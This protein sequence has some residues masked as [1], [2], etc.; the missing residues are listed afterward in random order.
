MYLNLKSLE[1]INYQT[2]NQLLPITFTCSNTA[3][4]YS[5]SRN[6]DYEINY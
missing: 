2:R 3:K 4:Q 1:H 5:V 6:N